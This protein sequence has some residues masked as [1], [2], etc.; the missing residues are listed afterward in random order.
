MF[1][2]LFISTSYPVNEKDWKGVFISNLLGSLSSNPEIELKYWGPPGVMP[3]SAKY[4]CTDDQAKWL[5][6]LTECGGIA[7]IIRQKNIKSISCVLKLLLFLFKAYKRN[8][9]VDL[10]HINWLQNAIPLLRTKKPA[11]ITVLGSDFGLLDL[12]GMVALLRFVLKNRRSAL[13]PN[14]DWMKEKLERLFGDISTIIPV[15]FG[16]DDAWFNV[17][18]CFSAENTKK[19]IVVSR[20]TEKKIGTLFDWGRN[21]FLTHPEHE[22]HLFGPMQ[23]NLNVPDWIHYHGPTNPEEL[24]KIW[25]PQSCG[26]ITLSRHDEGR[27]Q[28]LLEAMASGLPVLASDLPAHTNFL[29]QKETGLIVRSEEEYIS[30]LE[31]LSDPTNNEVLSTSSRD[32]VKKE[33]GTWDDC[34]ARYVAIYQKLLSG[35]A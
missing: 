7:H 34:A 31:W 16:V 5:I 4:A 25:F 35:S 21:F 33:I 6:R 14:A 18:R 22:L 15:P 11:L 29:T 8:A 1:S 10:L 19:W 30:G 27:P 12:P 26:L 23:E 3:S 24:R 2:I 17:R 13:C 32:W 28:V 9:D 20:L